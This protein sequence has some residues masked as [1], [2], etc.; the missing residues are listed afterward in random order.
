MYVFTVE[1]LVS[2]RVP[3]DKPFCIVAPNAEEAI[4]E[5]KLLA[6]DLGHEKPSL[7][8][9]KQCGEVDRV[10]TKSNARRRR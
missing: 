8:S 5:A 4:E 7:G 6:S 10:R 9:L 1:L 3:L 2:G